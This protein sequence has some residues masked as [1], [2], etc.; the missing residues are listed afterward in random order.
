MRIPIRLGVLGGESQVTVA[1]NVVSKKPFRH[2]GSGV[3]KLPSIFSRV[4]KLRFFFL[5]G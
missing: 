3:F 5:F 2:H 4:E 1:G